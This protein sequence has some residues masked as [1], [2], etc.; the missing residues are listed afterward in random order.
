MHQQLLSSISGFVE[1]DT[2]VAVNINMPFLNINK[3]S[4]SVTPPP[5]PSKW[6]SLT[7]DKELANLNHR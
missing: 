6:K 4:P 3:V 5:G 2:I 7:I 1:L